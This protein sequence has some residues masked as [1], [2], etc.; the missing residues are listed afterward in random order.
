MD[1]NE[2][3]SVFKNIIG[4]KIN[5]FTKAG[6][7]LCLGIGEDVDFYSKYKKKTLKRAH[8][9]FHFQCPWRLLEA[10]KIILGSYD[11]YIDHNGEDIDLYVDNPSKSIFD[12]FVEKEEDKLKNLLVESITL[13]KQNDC[14]IHFSDQISFSTFT[15]SSYKQEFW[16]LIGFKEHTHY[17]L[18]E[19]GKDK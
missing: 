11:F 10:E 12:D 4:Q 19:D 7:M 9:D 2:I 16:R 6:D 17:V 18:Y 14:I 3:T 1:Q 8:Y 13:S 5:H 15:N